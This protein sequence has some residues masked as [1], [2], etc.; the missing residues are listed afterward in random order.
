MRKQVLEIPTTI[1][2]IMDSREFALGVIDG[3]AGRGHRSAYATWDGN[4]Q[5]DYEHGRQWAALAPRSVVLKRN[6]KLTAEAKRWFTA[7]I[8]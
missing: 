2:A 5:W 3:R 6:G 7:D 4:Q 8:L 1:E